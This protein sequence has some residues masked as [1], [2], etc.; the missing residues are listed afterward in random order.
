MSVCVSQ[1]L[2]VCLLGYTRNHVSKL[3][4]TFSQGL[5]LLWRLRTT[6]CIL[7]FVDVIAHS[8]RN[9][10]PLPSDTQRLSSDNYLK[11]AARTALCASMTVLHENDMYS[12]TRQ[13]VAPDWVRV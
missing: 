6:L 11:V 9:T 1:C 10:S 2:C 12:V 3:C 7:S 8:G 13:R 4:V 5:V